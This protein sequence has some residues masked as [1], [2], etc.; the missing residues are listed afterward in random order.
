MIFLKL[1][2]CLS[3]TVEEVLFSCWLVGSKIQSG[4]TEKFLNLLGKITKTV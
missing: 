1:P 3:T 4:Q 2:L